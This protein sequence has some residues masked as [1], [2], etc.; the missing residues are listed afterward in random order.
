MARRSIKAPVAVVTLE[1]ARAQRQPRYFTGR[2]CKFGHI[3]E[4]LTSNKTCMDCACRIQA[5]VYDRHG[6]KVRERVGIYRRSHKEAIAERDARYQR[7]NR[8]RLCRHYAERYMEKRAVLI[9]KIKAYKK[10][11]PGFSNEIGKAYLLRKRRAM[12]TWVDRGELRKI[13]AEAAL[14]TAQ[15]G[16][17]HS[18]DHI[19]PLKGANSCGLHI[20]WNLQ[21][22]PMVDN[23]RKGTKAPEEWQALR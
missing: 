1:Y 8:E 21:I 3:A 4:R 17:L 7:R 15:T 20:P 5:G 13:Y 19:Y 9:E 11:R 10:S 12:P 23:C 22:I 18:V 16:I 2:P 14:I 6:E